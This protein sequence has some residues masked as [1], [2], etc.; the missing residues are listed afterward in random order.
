MD[1]VETIAHAFGKS[2]HKMPNPRS[3][4]NAIRCA[5][6]AGRTYCIVIDD[7]VLKIQKRGRFVVTD[8]VS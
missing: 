6:T 5:L 3:A 8:V 1:A 7:T 2:D 4:R